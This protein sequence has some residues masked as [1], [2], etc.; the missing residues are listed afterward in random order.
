MVE[1]LLEMALLSDLERAEAGSTKLDPK[2]R[3]NDNARRDFLAIE[4]IM[5]F[6]II[7]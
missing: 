6:P 3:H 5:F 7:N 4:T 1:Q 2:A